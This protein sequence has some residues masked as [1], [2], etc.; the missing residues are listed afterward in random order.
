MEHVLKYVRNHSNVLV[1][2][3]HFWVKFSMIFV[4]EIIKISCDGF[5]SCC[6]CFSKGVYKVLVQPKMKR[7]HLLINAT[8]SHLKDFINNQFISWYWC[9]NVILCASGVIICLCQS[10]CSGKHY[11]PKS[12]TTRQQDP[13]KKKHLFWSRTYLRLCYSAFPP[14]LLYS[15]RSLIS[16]KDMFLSQ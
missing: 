5:F 15:G 3:V 12:I 14:S 9:Q 4:E 7:F 2:R 13:L 1:L 10:S 6:C 11:K 8:K 16:S